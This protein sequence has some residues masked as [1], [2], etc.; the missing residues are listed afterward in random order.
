MLRLRALLAIA[1]AF[2]VYPSVSLAGESVGFYA[3]GKLKGGVPLPEEG[4]H[5]YLVMRARCYEDG[6]R[7]HN[8]YGHPNTVRA[9]QEAAK[10]V[11]TTY[12]GA[13]KVAVGE[14]SNRRGGKI[15]HHLSHQNGLD[16]D[17]YFLQRPDVEVC[18]H[19][20]KVFEVRRRGE[21]QLH[22]DFDVPMNWA[23]V[24]AFAERRDVKRIFIGGLIRQELAA[25]AKKNIPRRERRRTL[26][27]LHASFCKAPPGVNMGTYKNNRCPHDDHIHVR[28]KCPKDSDQCRERRKPRRKERARLVRPHDDALASAR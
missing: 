13:P 4:K 14:L 19:Y 22:E 9:V 25:Y 7:A 5:H 24:S 3:S 20:A 1:S 11:R 8:Y 10:K 27:K 23:L 21:W 17:V 28:F 2:A 6:D 26:K 15:P 18:E 12:L 16:V